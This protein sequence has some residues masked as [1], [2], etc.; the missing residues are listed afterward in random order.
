MHFLCVCVCVCVCCVCCWFKE[1]NATDGL[2]SVRLV[3]YKIIGN[4]EQQE[5]TMGFPTNQCIVIMM[6]CVCVCVR[7][8]VCVCA[9]VRACVCVCEW[10]CVFVCVCCCVSNAFRMISP[11]PPLSLKKIVNR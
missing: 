9:C 6:V 1:V 4:S 11:P 2:Y 3:W 5:R 8:C 10:V 7:V